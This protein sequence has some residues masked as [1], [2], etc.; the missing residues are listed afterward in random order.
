MIEAPEYH[1]SFTLEFKTL[2]RW[3]NLRGA[4]IAH[5]VDR[6]SKHHILASVGKTFA[7]CLSGRDVFTGWFHQIRW[8]CCVFVAVSISPCKTY[9]CQLSN[10][11]TGAKYSKGKKK[12]KR[13]WKSWNIP[14]KQVSR[15]HEKNVP[16]A[17]FLAIIYIYWWL[18]KE[19]PYWL[20]SWFWSGYV[21]IVATWCATRC[22]W[23]VH[24]PGTREI[25]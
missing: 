4:R 12:K 3:K 22:F 25:P 24:R 16:S 19:L 5:D 20:Y 18:N 7:A 6:T 11:K 14:N 21:G 15:H 2:S 8:S 9:S 17:K 10:R 23:L 1:F 13:K